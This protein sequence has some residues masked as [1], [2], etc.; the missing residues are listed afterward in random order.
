MRMQTIKPV[1]LKRENMKVKKIIVACVLACV[2]FSSCFAL[3]ACGDKNKKNDKAIIYVTALF[4]GGL[5]DQETNEAVWEPFKTEIDAVKVMK[6]EMEMKEIVS[7]FKD[8]FSD[9]L[10]LVGSAVS[11][12]EGSLLWNLTLDNEGNSYNPNIAPANG[13]PKDSNGNVMDVSYGAFGIYKNFVDHISAEYG[14]RYDVT[15]YNQDWRMSPAKS[16]ADLENFIE[17]NGYKEVIFM[18]HSMGA[19]VVNNYLARSEANRNK[20]K[21]YMGFAPAT[22]GSFDALAAMTCPDV[23]VDNF[24]GGMDLSGLPVD[25]YAIVDSIVNGKLGDFFRNNLG[26][27]SLVP[28]WQL[29]S[30][31]QYDADNPAITVDG[32]AIETKDELYNL[33]KS[34]RWAK[35]LVPRTKQEIKDSDDGAD[36]SRVRAEKGQHSDEEGYR[37]KD[38]AANLDDYFDNMFINGKIASESIANSYYF[39]GTGGKATITNL[40]LTTIKDD[41]G[42][43]VYDD[44]GCVKYNYKLVTAGGAQSK[45]GDGTVPYYSS[46]GGNTAT[47]E[48][49]ASLGNRLVELEGENHGMVGVDWDLLGPHVMALLK[50]FA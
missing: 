11:Y 26:L 18:S 44:Y 22:L 16:A 40:E 45:L 29:I 10:K 31:D 36:Y 37:I 3:A 41:D 5:Y 43:I 7:H 33:Y 27:M 32:K 17:S 19:P 38:F 14:D 28:S 12:K 2:V 1:F 49:L 8:E 9:I 21:L 47:A 20:V 46:I 13:L 48:Y 23:Y 50:Q 6:G 42:N 15:V 4:G 39:L 35:Y 30:S 25:V 34:M 24:L